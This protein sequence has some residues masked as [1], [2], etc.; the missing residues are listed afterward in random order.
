MSIPANGLRL[1]NRLGVYEPL[2]RGGSVTQEII[3]HSTSGNELGRLD[4]A[5]DSEATTGYEPM[6]IKRTVLMDALFT[7]AH[8]LDIPI[9]FGRRPVS[10]TE[11][12]AQNATVTFADGSNDTAD[13]LLGCDGIH[14]A[15][16]SL[17]VDPGVMPEY[18]GLSSM[19]SIVPKSTDLTGLNIT[20]ISQGAVVVLPCTDHGHPQHNDNDSDKD[21]EQEKELFWFL[22]RHI[23]P[24][25]STDRDGWNEHRQKEVTSF[26]T[27]VLDLLHNV[28]GPWGSFLR[29]IVSSTQSVN[30]YPIYRLP[31][32]GV[33]HTNRCML[34]G[35]AAHAMQPHAGQGVS[36]AM[37]DVF[38][39]SRL[40]KQ[41][42]LNIK[43]CLSRFEAIRRPRVEYMASQAARNGQ[44]ARP[45]G[46]WE[47]AVKEWGM[48]AWLWASRAFS[49]SSSW[50]FRKED[51]EYDIDEVDLD[52]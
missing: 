51:V 13:I 48:W 10:V 45:M 5:S 18:S 36:M 27:T 42:S 12:A 6:R 28:D 24:P 26:K 49:S 21:K 19:S 23:T 11:D 8:A 35:G 22:T 29:D 34:L 31:R 14:S 52:G 3:V 4:L 33:W 25:T 7:A 1:L 50:G 20:F 2:R 47:M 37:E 39:L 16:R 32:G 30:F 15:V 17:H 9:H 46:L 44:R 40:L 38:F 41:D 43:D